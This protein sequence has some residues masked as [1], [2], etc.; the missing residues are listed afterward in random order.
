MCNVSNWK[1]IQERNE[2]TWKRK[3][4]ENWKSFLTLI[5]HLPINKFQCIWEKLQSGKCFQVNVSAFFFHLLKMFSKL[6]MFQNWKCFQVNVSAF[7]S[8]WRNYCFNHIMLHMLHYV[9]YVTLCYMTMLHMLYDYVTYITWY[10]I[11]HETTICKIKVG[12]A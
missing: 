10:Y 4:P 9:T 7:F 2:I 11:I 1:C 6:K 5:E 8:L 3:A 12:W